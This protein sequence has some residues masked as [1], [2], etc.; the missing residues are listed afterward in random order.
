MT[1]IYQIKVKEHLPAD[2]GNWVEGLQ[3]QTQ[4]DGTTLLTV[5]VPDQ[6]ALHGLLG[7]IRDT[8]V[9]LLVLH[10][11]AKDKK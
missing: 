5:A 4:P 1:T 10:L 8:G 7:Y 2:W 11:V 9:T 3:L 6:A